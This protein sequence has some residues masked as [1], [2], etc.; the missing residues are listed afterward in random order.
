VLGHPTEVVTEAAKPNPHYPQETT[1]KWLALDLNCISL[2]DRYVKDDG[3]E[4]V[5]VN[6]E[7]IYVQVGEPRADYFDIPANY[8]ER[9][10][11]DIDSEMQKKFGRHVLGEGDP[12]VRD[13]LQ[14]AYQATKL[15]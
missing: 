4:V 11:A 5:Q 7:A 13:K 3:S 9:G 15:R 2:R 8:Q 6:R 12:A 10:P 1:T 14:Q